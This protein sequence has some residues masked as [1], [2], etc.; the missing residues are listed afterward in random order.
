MIFAHKM[1]RNEFIYENIN[2]CTCKSQNNVDRSTRHLNLYD[3]A[4]GT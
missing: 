1:N 2:R 3:L 4:K